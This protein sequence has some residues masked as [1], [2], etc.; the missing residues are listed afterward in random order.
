MSVG[1]KV[2]TQLARH[3]PRLEEAVV[4][5]NWRRHNRDRAFDPAAIN[6]PVQHRLV[7]DLT[8]DGVAMTTFDE[9]VGTPELFEEAAARARQL[10]ADW[11]PEEAAEGSKAS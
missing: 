11:R 5:A 10:H 1:A 3:A 7:G 6:D 4:R 9:L 2:R 8:R